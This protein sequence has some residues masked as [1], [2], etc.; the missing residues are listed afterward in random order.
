VRFCR[1]KRDRRAVGQRNR[2]E[3]ARRIGIDTRI[4]VVDLGR[5]I[6]EVKLTSI[7]VKSDQRERTVVDRSVNA[8]VDSTHKTHVGIE[9]ERLG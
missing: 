6:Y 5:E 3:Q 4:E 1:T 9:E 7:K 8:N 2:P